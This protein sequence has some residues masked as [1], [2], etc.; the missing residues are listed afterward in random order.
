MEWK[1]GVKG[2]SDSRQVFQTGNRGKIKGGAGAKGWGG[3]C[4]EWE[5]LILINDAIKS[6][7]LLSVLISII[8][9]G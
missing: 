2:R 5:I 4:I 6:L 8:R 7:T 1:S 3:L 9:R